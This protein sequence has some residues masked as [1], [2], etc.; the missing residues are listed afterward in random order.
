VAQE[1]LLSA[2]ET[3]SRVETFLID[4][5]TA[6]DTG[7]QQYEKA[8]RGELLPSA[9]RDVQGIRFGQETDPG[10]FEPPFS[11]PGRAL[12]GDPAAIAAAGAAAA[13]EL[14]TVWS[15]FSD[16]LNANVEQTRL[17]A[18]IERLTKKVADLSK[19]CE[20]LEEAKK[21]GSILIP[22]EIIGAP[23]TEKTPGIETSLAS[24]IEELNKACSPGST[25]SP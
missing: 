22:S 7:H 17:Q 6:L 9:N 14:A 21:G 18:E 2:G 8:L 16:T 15:E 19:E 12:G 4:L 1:T 20:E 10:G 24:C 23:A 25:K 13:D 3:V 11:V 5:Y